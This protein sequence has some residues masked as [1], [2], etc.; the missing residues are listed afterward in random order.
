MVGGVDSRGHRGHE[1][2]LCIRDL[3]SGKS[4]PRLLGFLNGYDPFCAVRCV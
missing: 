3:A 2:L 4:A 1:L